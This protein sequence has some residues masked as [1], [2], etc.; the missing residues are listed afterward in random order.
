[1]NNCSWVY[2]FLRD[3][4]SDIL[5]LIVRTMIINGNKLVPVIE[6]ISV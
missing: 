5:K 4:S 1:M 6:Y 3:I 2:G